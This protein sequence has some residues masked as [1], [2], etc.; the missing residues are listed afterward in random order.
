[1]LPLYSLSLQDACKLAETK[2]SGKR[3]PNAVDTLPA[4][5][6]LNFHLI[7]GKGNCIRSSHSFIRDPNLSLV[8]IFIV[9]LLNMYYVAHIVLSANLGE[10]LSH[11]G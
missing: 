3:F 4:A 5:Q 7:K 6:V 11:R 1:M 10:G 8:H 2:N 9:V